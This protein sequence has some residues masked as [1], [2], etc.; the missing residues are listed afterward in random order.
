MRVWLALVLTAIAL[1]AADVKPADPVERLSHVDLYAFGGVG[2]AGT[3]SQGQQD[4]DAILV[5]RSAKLDFEKIFSSGN[6]QAKAYALNGIYKLDPARFRA[7]NEQLRMETTK[8]RT[9]HGCILGLETLGSIV[10]GIGK[11]GAK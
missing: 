10:Q 1:S 2:F 4:Y 9:A 5:R 3:T 11:S 7:L 6:P 8:V